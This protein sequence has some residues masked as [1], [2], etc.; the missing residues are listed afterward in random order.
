MSSTGGAR[1]DA[2]A[3]PA[4]RPGRVGAVLIVAGAALAADIVSKA[5][6]AA[7]LEEPHVVRLLG[8]A[9]YLVQ[10]RNAG[11]AFSIGA[12]ASMTVV[13]TVVAA[14]VAAVI[15]RVARRLRSRSWAVGLGL[16]L[17]GAVGNLVDRLFRAPGFGRGHVVDWISVFDDHGGRFPIFNLADSAITCGAVLAVALAMLGIDFDGARQRRA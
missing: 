16:I 6:V 17:G 13:F 11:A 5:I 10:A 3:A 15:V 8:G 12:D 9:L 4:D 2:A 7:R 1:E 14:V